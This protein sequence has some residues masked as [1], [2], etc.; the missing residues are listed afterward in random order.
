MRSDA[1]RI[2]LGRVRGHRGDSGEITVIVWFGEAA[3]WVGLD[4]V[5]LDRRG[6]RGLGAPRGARPRVS[7]STGAQ[8]ARHRWTDRGGRAP[9][10]ARACRGRRCACGRGRALP[11][12]AARRAPGDGRIRDR[13]R[14]RDRRRTHRRTWTVGHRAADRPPANRCCFR[15]CPRSWGTSTRSPG[16]SSCARRRGCSSSTARRARALELRRGDVVPGDVR[17]AAARRHARARAS[18]GARRRADAR[19]AALGRGGPSPG[20]RRAV[21][22]RAEGWS[23]V[24]SRCS[25]P[26]TGSGAATRRRL[27]ASSCFRLRAPGW[28]TGR[29]ERLAG[30]DRVVLLCGRYEGVDERVREGLAD[31]ETQYRRRGADR[32]GDAGAGRDRR[33]LALRPGGSGAAEAALEDSFADG[34]L[35][36]PYYTRPAEFRGRRVPEVLLSGDHEAIA[37]WRAQRALEPR[38]ASGP[39]CSRRAAPEALAARWGIGTWI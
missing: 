5:V 24:P 12:A 10:C 38:G 31:E 29:R 15:R 30:Y 11:S 16:P 18:R 2:P 26:W 25:R 35:D 21:R 33:R 36:S 37:R 13:A 3:F 34:R 27:S 4:R 19:P 32:R 1:R 23:C 6:S 39:T 14:S 8:A 9:R 28:T 22:G 7:G 20:R 17:R